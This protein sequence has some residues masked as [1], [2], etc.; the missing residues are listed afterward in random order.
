MTA[1]I[2]PVA[3]R[4]VRADGS[5]SKWKDMPPRKIRPVDGKGAR[6][7]FA[8][9]APATVELVKQEKKIDN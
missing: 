7:E 3:W 6:I 5:R 9:P 1:D 4:I 2:K 8:Y